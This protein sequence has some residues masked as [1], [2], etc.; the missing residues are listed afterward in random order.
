MPPPTSLCREIRSASVSLLNLALVTALAALA[1]DATVRSPHERAP[2]GKRAAC[3]SGRQLGRSRPPLWRDSA[4]PTEA[5]RG[6]GTARR[7]PTRE[8]ALPGGAAS[9]RGSRQ[10]RRPVAGALLPSRPGL[11][12]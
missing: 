7:D 4:Q 10:D 8:P 5:F 2:A 12:G 9:L 1:K 6:A 11:G 3:A